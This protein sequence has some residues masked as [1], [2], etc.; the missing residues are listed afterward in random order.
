[1]MSNLHR[2]HD[3]ASTVH[4]NGSSSSSM[5]SGVVHCN[6]IGGSSS[7]ATNG[8]SNGG[9]TV[10]NGS[11]GSTSITVTDGIVPLTSSIAGVGVGGVI[12]VMDT[13]TM[14]PLPN[15]NYGFDGSV[16]RVK[17]MVHHPVKNI[18]FGIATND[19]EHTLRWCYM[20]TATWDIYD[21]NSG[22]TIN[23]YGY[24]GIGD[25]SVVVNHTS[26]DVHYHMKGGILKKTYTDGS[27]D[28]NG[29]SMGFSQGGVPFGLRGKVFYTA[30]GNEVKMDNNVMMD[31]SKEALPKS[32]KV[33]YVKK[34]NGK[35]YYDVYAT[36]GINDDVHLNVMVQSHDW[37]ARHYKQ[38]IIAYL[39][40]QI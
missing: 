23:V 22:A 18:T 40:S 6:A 38:A 10:S 3:N 1:M 32:V 14:L 39:E 12:G 17:V 27:K 19:I 11:D 4:S 35:I 15:V 37:E 28:H 25:I 26:I 34:V 30:M 31:G 16:K 8:S 7:N 29:A 9:S 2:V 24:D 13:S 33:M 20:N 5:S 36:Y 21:E